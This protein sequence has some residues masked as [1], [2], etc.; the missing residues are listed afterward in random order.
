MKSLI[1][2]S[3]FLILCGCEELPFTNEDIIVNQ[4]KE[5]KNTKEEIKEL[6]SLQTESNPPLPERK[7]EVP[8]IQEEDKTEIQAT[9]ETPLEEE[10]ENEEPHLLEEEITFISEDLELKEDTVIQ[11]RQVVLDMVKIKTFEHNLFIIAEEFVSNH[12]I[13]RNFPEGE[14][15]KKF[16]NGRNGG[17]ILIETEKAIGEL[18]LV[19]NGEE[20]G[21]VPRRRTIS[22]EHK[23]RLR[24]EKGRDGQ[25]ATYRRFCRNMTIPLALR[26]ISV[27]FVSS[28][29]PVGRCFEV[30]SSLPTEG[31]DGRKGLRGVPGFNGKN[32]GSSGSFHLKAFE[33][34][35]FHLVNIKS[36]PGLASPGG[37]GSHGGYGGK[38]GRNGIDSKG[39][40]KKQKLSQ[41]DSG[42]RGR[43]GV[44]GKDG[45]DGTKGEVCI[46]KLISSKEQGIRTI[47]TQ[48]EV[49]TVCEDIGEGRSCREVLV[50][51][52]ENT[53]CY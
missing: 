26:L 46:E 31:E 20:A 37:K 39:L 45:R 50:Q 43:R 41:P 24:G 51:K 48:S 10:K 6:D 34:S 3:G 17:N 40:C 28:A 53:I 47:K 13:I 32:G 19:L 7:E 42:D 33:F 2:L 52:K 1:L 8:V 16:Q 30:C 12:S 35:D 15:A 38:R 21:R 22:K 29:L 44:H 27:P 36:T 4:P 14:K 18:Q 11:N 49:E 23:E 25:N 5:R 9:E